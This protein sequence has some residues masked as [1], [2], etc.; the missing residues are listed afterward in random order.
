MIVA[1]DSETYR[2]LPGLLAPPPVCWS[3]ATDGGKVELLG[4]ADGAWLL[5]DLL[6]TDAVLV[7]HHVAYDFAVLCAYRPEYTPLVFRA[8][9]D[10]RIRD[11]KI[12]Q[13]LLDI[14]AGLRKS[15]GV[16]FT[17]R[18]GQWVRQDVSLAGSAAIPGSLGLVHYHLGKDR[19]A[20]KTD[21]ASWRVRYHELDGVPL[22]EWPRKPV[23]YALADAVDTLAVYRAQGP[24]VL[25]NEV[26]QVRKAFDL[27]LISTHGMRSEA[28]Y[29]DALERD[30]L[31]QQA[32]LRTRLL[33]EGLMKIDR[34][35][36]EHRREGKV[37]FWAPIPS[38]RNA[39]KSAAWRFTK[40]AAAVQARVVAAYAKI[41]EPVPYTDPTARHSSGQVKTDSDTL[42]QSGDDLLE[43]MGEKGPLNTISNVFLP[44][45][46]LGTK[47]PINT[48]Y[49]PL[50]ET[51]RISSFRPNL[52]NI[53]RGGGVRE[54][55]VPRPGR[56][57]CSTDLDCAE[58][59]SHAQV[60]LW[61]FGHSAMADFF[62]ASPR[63]DPHLELAAD[64]LSIT[65]AEANRRRKAGDAEVKGVRQMAKAINFGLPGGMGLK[66]LI[67]TA[68]KQYGVILS[69]ARARELKRKWLARWPEMRLYFEYWSTRTANG[70]TWTMQLRPPGVG[71]PHRI[72]GAVG[73]CDGCNGDFQAL[74][75]DAAAEALHLIMEECYVVRDSPLF[76]SRVVGFFY[77][78]VLSEVPVE[79]A[80]EAAFRQAELMVQGVMRWTPDVPATCTPALCERWYKGAEAVFDAS[81]RL[82]PWAP[83]V[84]DKS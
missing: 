80:H 69:E 23:D 27:Q 45:L 75:A 9:A 70:E 35:S 12:R 4:A 28:E 20:D 42:E 63:G 18:R 68:R 24:D 14:E 74:T 60:N 38:G 46:R 44:T 37:D 55:F 2:I 77:D 33:A 78:E 79:R 1:F 5:Y 32:E 66:R 3:F 57:F 62:R 15:S 76:G 47:V 7:G 48:G 16:V 11:T 34:A 52:N 50:L 41:D 22:H 82:V 8:Y 13:Q 30:V 71:T 21:A 61:R 73:Y 19:S 31:R 59:R 51:G 10:G 64:I 84:V 54:C 49:N 58:L 67:E 56:L 53:P 6:R 81:G 36:A 65:Y 40:D 25:V 83:A 43:E 39:G 26:E 17:L 72:R 29:V